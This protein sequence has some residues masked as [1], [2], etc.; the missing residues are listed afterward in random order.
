MSYLTY[1][2]CITVVLQKGK[3]G[4]R[5]ERLL[6]GIIRTAVSTTISTS[7]VQVPSLCNGGGEY[8]VLQIKINLIKYYSQELRTTHAMGE[9][10]SGLV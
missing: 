7:V 9:D 1:R 6:V 8:S 5:K 10:E 4:D 3:C 2:L